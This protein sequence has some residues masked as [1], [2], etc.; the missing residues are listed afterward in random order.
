VST[1][2]LRLLAEIFVGTAPLEAVDM[3]QIEERTGIK[4]TRD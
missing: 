3:K 1:T 4:I 2:A